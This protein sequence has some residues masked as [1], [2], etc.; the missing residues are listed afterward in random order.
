MRTSAWQPDEQ[1]DD[2]LPKKEKK[3]SKG[4]TEMAS[5]LQRALYMSLA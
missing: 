2:H 1:T 4:V 3:E 5:E